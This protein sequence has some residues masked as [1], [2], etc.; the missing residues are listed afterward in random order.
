MK[1]GLNVENCHKNKSH[2]AFQTPDTLSFHNRMLNILNLISVLQSMFPSIIVSDSL[3]P[4][5]TGCEG[6]VTLS[7]SFLCSCVWPQW[8]SRSPMASERSWHR[9]LSDQESTTCSPYPSADL[10][11]WQAL[12]DGG[13]T[14]S[15][16]TPVPSTLGFHT[17]LGTAVSEMG[18]NGGHG[19]GCLGK[20][21]WPWMQAWAE[22]EAGGESILPLTDRCSCLYL[23]LLYF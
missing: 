7:P 3:Q 2:P 19:S 9:P 18:V 5:H 20:M 6:P 16:D 8:L 11:E 17:C 1:H 4:W 15:K 14:W 21:L 12:N 23:C 10:W 22:T 13:V